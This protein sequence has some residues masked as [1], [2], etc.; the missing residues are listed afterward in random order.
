MVR[1]PPHRA[2]AGPRHYPGR[3]LLV[4]SR[5]LQNETLRDPLFREVLDFV[6]LPTGTEPAT[7]SLA[8]QVH[9]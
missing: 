1:S 8:T 4:P 5:Q 3:V 6:G 9:F 7:G 2:H